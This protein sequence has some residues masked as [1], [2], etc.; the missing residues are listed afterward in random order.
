MKVLKSEVMSPRIA[1]FNLL[2]FLKLLA[3][4][5][6]VICILLSIAYGVREAIEHT[7]HR[8]PDFRLQVIDLTPNDVLDETELVEHLKIDLTSNI[9]DLDVDRMEEELLEIPAISSAKVE[10]ELPGTLSFKI[11]TRKPVA[12]IAC[13]SEG[14]PATRAEGSLLVD[15]LGYT[16]PCPALQLN[17]ASQLPIFIL[18]SNPEHPLQVA[19]TTGHPEY[20]HCMQLL[21]SFRSTYPDDISMIESISQTNAWSLNLKTRTGTEATFGLGGNERQL[22]YFGQALHHARGKGYQIATINLIP[23]RNV[24]ITILGGDQPP[25]AIPVLEQPVSNALETRRDNDLRSLL[26]RN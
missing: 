14:I 17:Q 3:K 7:F 18:N 5:A 2:G 26:N 10:R 21:N 24:P 13:P 4:F 20:R 23:K 16:Y 9:F 8:N 12:W 22:D 15:E 11:L 6:V 19:K 1:W 25:R